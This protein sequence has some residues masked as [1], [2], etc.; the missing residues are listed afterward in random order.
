VVSI[1]GMADGEVA[2]AVERVVWMLGASGEVEVAEVLRG[3]SD[4]WTVAVGED[5]LGE[6]V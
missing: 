6:V 5:I 2:R 1:A 3:R 4:V